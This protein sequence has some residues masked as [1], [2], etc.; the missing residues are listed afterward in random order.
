MPGCLELRRRACVQLLL[1]R[2]SL[3]CILAS[4]ATVERAAV[5]RR[6]LSP[7]TVSA[8]TFL[9]LPLASS[10]VDGA[11]RGCCSASGPCMS[12]PDAP[13][14]SA[15]VVVGRTSSSACRCP[16]SSE[17]VADVHVHGVRR[18]SAP[19]SACPVV[20][21]PVVPPCCVTSSRRCVPPPDQSRTPS[22][23]VDVALQG[24]L[25]LVAST[26]AECCSSV[27]C[28][29]C[30]SS[31]STALRRRRARRLAPSPCA[32]A[33]RRVAP[34]GSAVPAISSNSGR[35]QRRFDTAHLTFPHGV[36]AHLCCQSQDSSPYAPDTYERQTGPALRERCG[37]VRRARRRG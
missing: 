32:A 5:V 17:L 18:C 7:S 35:R 11:G 29:A 28:D 19:S 3:D 22:D 20:G 8:P 33:R 27:L 37:A 21:R 6:S 9:T 23:L 34:A 1:A 31:A 16:P 12:A 36:P 30:L 10:S 4:S 25:R 13:A 24:A 14:C 26:L 2:A 15:S